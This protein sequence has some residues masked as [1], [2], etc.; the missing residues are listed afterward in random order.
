MSHRGDSVPRKVSQSITGQFLVGPPRLGSVVSSSELPSSLGKHWPLIWLPKPQSL[1][2]GLKWTPV[3]VG[4]LAQFLWIL[5]VNFLYCSHTL[6]DQNSSFSGPTNTSTFRFSILSEVERQMRAR[7]KSCLH[8]LSAGVIRLIRMRMA[9]DWHGVESLL[10]AAGV[11]KGGLLC[12]HLCPYTTFRWSR[13]SRFSLSNCK[14][15][16]RVKEVRAP[17]YTWQIICH[18]ARGARNFSWI[19]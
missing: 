15:V 4:Q 1:L 3:L 11:E 5:R 14:E 8:R 18:P 19:D 10:V 12:N 13:N 9:T 6:G 16:W 17:H 2:A 7:S